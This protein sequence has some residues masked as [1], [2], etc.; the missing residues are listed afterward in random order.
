VA[1]DKVEEYFD[2]FVKKCS[3]LLYLKN[4]AW[5][6]VGTCNDD[7]CEKL[8]LHGVLK[9]GTK[10]LEAFLNT[11]RGNFVPVGERC[12]LFELMGG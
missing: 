9:E 1:N 12:S 7:L 2:L 4:M 5:L 8:V 10:Y 6:S 11:D 3:Q